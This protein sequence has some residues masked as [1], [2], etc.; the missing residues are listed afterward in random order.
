MK[1]FRKKKKPNQWKISDV[2]SEGTRK[3]DTDL[4]DNPASGLTP[5]KYDIPEEILSFYYKDFYTLAEKMLSSGCVDVGNKNYMDETILARVNNALVILSKQRSVH[6]HHT[7]HDIDT[8]QKAKLE[9]LRLEKKLAQDE[10]TALDTK[11]PE[12]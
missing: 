11:Y 5:K 1:I 6:E 9:R 10:L 2:T 8:I 4:S 3:V 7:L 12:E